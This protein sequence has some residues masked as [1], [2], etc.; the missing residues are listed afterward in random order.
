VTLIGLSLSVNVCGGKNLLKFVGKI[1][2]TLSALRCNLVMDGSF[3]SI[4]SCILFTFTSK[5]L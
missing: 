1:D 5:R 2:H 3:L 4:F